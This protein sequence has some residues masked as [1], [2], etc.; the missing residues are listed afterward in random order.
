MRLTALLRHRPACLSRCIPGG[1]EA[2]DEAPAATAMRSRWLA[3]QAP[4]S[5]AGLTAGSG[6]YRLVPISETARSANSPL[7]TLTLANPGR[8]FAPQGTP[9]WS[10]KTASP[11]LAEV[12]HCGFLASLQRC[13]DCFVAGTS[14]QVGFCAYVVSL[15]A[16]RASSS[17]T[18]FWLGLSHTGFPSKA[19]SET[20]LRAPG[21]RPQGADRGSHVLSI[22]CPSL[23]SR[24][25]VY[26]PP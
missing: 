8:C 7:C 1:E 15:F 3:R 6:L 10:P 5:E 9:S 19:L 26:G 16:L 22:P 4:A 18:A 14:R 2:R 11:A 23:S 21:V 12:P 25:P 20:H 24:T 13:L 17:S